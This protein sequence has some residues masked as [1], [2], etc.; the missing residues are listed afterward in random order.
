MKT[1]AHKRKI[2]ND[3]VHGFITIPHPLLFDIVEHPY[4]QRLRR[5]K[6]LGLSDYVYPGALHTRFH[7]ALG[8]FHL[9]RKALSVLRLKGQVITE[10]EEI[11]AC[12]AILLHDIGHGPFSHTLEHVLIPKLSHENISKV[13]MQALNK[14]FKGK[15][16]LAIEIFE[17]SY[18]KKFLHQLVSSQLDTDRLDYIS[19]DSFYT[20]VSEGTIAYD[21]IIEMMNVRKNELVVEQKGIYSVENFLIARRLMYWQ[22]YLHKTV[23]SVEQM[24]IKAVERAKTLIDQGKHLDCSPPLQYFLSKHVSL[25]NF[26]QGD[27]LIYYSMLDDNDI[28]SALKRWQFAQDKVLKRLSAGIL[29]RKLFKIQLREKAFTKHEVNEAITQTSKKLGVSMAEA[30]SLIILQSTNNYAYN[31]DEKPIKILD[32][33]EQLLDVAKA[34]DLLNISVLSHPV[35]KHFLCYPK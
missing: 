17:G 4:F 27:A 21:R 28:M 24:L 14:E 5:I 10:K 6:Q 12:A 2:F 22:V 34:A 25:K 1:P 9:M 30:K 33:N 8:A 32:K 15:L 7:H 29:E 31:P 16:T 13:Y 35:V 18:P 11:A 3:P 26:E 19:R 20:G 23:L